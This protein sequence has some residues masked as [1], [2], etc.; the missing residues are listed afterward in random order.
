MAPKAKLPA[1]QKM[2]AEMR[3]LFSSADVETVNALHVSDFFQGMDQDQLAHGFQQVLDK[4]KR[5]QGGWNHVAAETFYPAA[6]LPGEC[7]DFWLA[8]LASPMG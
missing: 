3:K 6:P 2:D 8:I 4:V 7:R 1:I 5:L